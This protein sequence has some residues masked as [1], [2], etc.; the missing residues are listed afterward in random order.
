MSDMDHTPAEILS[1]CPAE[2]AFL[3]DSVRLYAEFLADQGC[4]LFGVYFDDLSCEFVSQ[5]HIGWIVDMIPQA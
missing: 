4:V 5:Y 3:A 1:S 2:L